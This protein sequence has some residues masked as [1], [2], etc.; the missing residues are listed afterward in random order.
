MINGFQTQNVMI[1]VYSI[2]VRK[3]GTVNA[4]DPV[5]D[6]VRFKISKN[7]IYKNDAAILNIIAAN[8]WKRPICFTSPYGELGFDRYLRQEGMTYRLVP[9]DNGGATQV[10]GDWVVKTMLNNYRFGNVQTP[11]VYFDEENRRHLNS[12]RLAFAQAAGSLAEIGRKDDAIKLLNRID[13]VMN[14]NNL[15]YAMPSRYQ[16]HNQISMQMVYACYRAGETKLAEKVSA[17]LKKDMEQ[18][19]AYIQGL[20]DKFQQSLAPDLER[21]DSFLKGLIQLEQQF[22]MIKQEIPAPAP[23]VNQAQTDTA[24]P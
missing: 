13:S 18:Q 12:I 24:K 20:S 8:K 4:N 9:I 3:N 14:S 21:I 7:Y 1:P 17:L 11:G 6:A 19:I 10:N 2:F 5:L 23:V 22:K 16:Q 15:P